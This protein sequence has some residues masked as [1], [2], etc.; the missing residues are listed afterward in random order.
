MLDIM[1]G[2]LEELSDDD[3]GGFQVRASR[4]LGQAPDLSRSSPQLPVQNG[5]GTGIRIKLSIQNGAQRV[6]AGH[7]SITPKPRPRII[8]K[9][10]QRPVE[11]DNDEGEELEPSPPSFV[12]L[13][14]ERRK[15]RKSS[16]RKRRRK[17]VAMDDSDDEDFDPVAE[18]RRKTS[19]KSREAVVANAPV[20]SSLVVE[21]IDL[22]GDEALNKNLQEDYRVVS[23]S[24]LGSKQQV[25]VNPITKTLQKCDLI[26]ASLKSE[27]KA[28]ST[29]EDAVAADRYAEVD[30]SAAKIVSQVCYA[31]SRS[32]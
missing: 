4:I 30:A 31:S 1:R 28:S 9:R 13:E 6:V 5:A 14:E 17:M 16:N 12:E 27:L 23:H 32:M 8:I 29:S 18:V 20:L 2:N 15:S 11:L 7:D 22:L 19:H 3:R 25:E 26:A 21:K 24:F 10:P